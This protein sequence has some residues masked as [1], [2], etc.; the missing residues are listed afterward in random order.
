MCWW[1]TCRQVRILQMCINTCC[2]VVLL[3]CCL[4]GPSHGLGALDLLVV[5]CR[6]VMACMFPAS[7]A[8]LRSLR[9]MVRTAFPL[10]VSGCRL[11]QL[12][13]HRKGGGLSDECLRGACKALRR[14][15]AVTVTRQHAADRISLVTY[16]WLCCRSHSATLCT[17]LLLLHL[18]LQAL[19]TRRLAWGSG[20]RLLEQSSCQRRRTWRC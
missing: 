1:W 6:Q 12:H 10:Q 14:G 13:H 4:L 17:A 16:M 9:V 3:S 11:R 18:L 19:A 2:W 15:F 7:F 20:C 8:C 5:T